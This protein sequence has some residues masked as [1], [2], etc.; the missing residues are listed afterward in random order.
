MIPY[1]QIFIIYHNW[2]MR[3]EDFSVEKQ[4]FFS[5]KDPLCGG[6][7][8]CLMHLMLPKTTDSRL[9]NDLFHQSRILRLIERGIKRAGF[10]PAQIGA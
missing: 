4:R 9:G 8:L 3:P 7:F 10:S 1:N 6:S 2:I 5:F